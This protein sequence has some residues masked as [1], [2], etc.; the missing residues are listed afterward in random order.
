VVTGKVSAWRTI[1]GDAA[2]YAGACQGLCQEAPI[3][4]MVKA[5]LDAEPGMNWSA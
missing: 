2:H 4:E 3:A 5:R 1:D